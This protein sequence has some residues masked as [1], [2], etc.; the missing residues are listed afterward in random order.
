MMHRRFTVAMFIALGSVLLI[1]DVHADDLPQKDKPDRRRITPK[2]STGPAEAA[3]AEPATS[4]EKDT[5]GNRAARGSNNGN[6][7]ANAN[8][9]DGDED[10]RAERAS[11]DDDDDRSGIRIRV[12][13]HNCACYSCRRR[14]SDRVVDD[15][16]DEIDRLERHA[17]EARDQM[18]RADDIILAL[19]HDLHEAQKDLADAE[20]DALPG[21]EE[22]AAARKDLASASLKVRAEDERIDAIINRIQKN[23]LTSDELEEARSQ[24]RE[25]EAARDATIAALIASM[26]Q[27]AVII[28][29]EAQITKAQQT[30]EQLQRAD[31]RDVQ[32]ITQIAMQLV[33]LKQ[34]LADT[35]EAYV[36]EHEEVIATRATVEMLKKRIAQLELELRAA[37]RA[38]LN[39]DENYNT[40]LAD[41]SAAREIEVAMDEVYKTIAAEHEPAERIVRLEQQNID[42]IRSRIAEYQA[43]REALRKEL[44][45]LEDRVAD[46]EDR[47][48]DVRRGRY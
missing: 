1:G 41:R 26:N 33:Q 34:A 6:H 8:N 27:D 24:L 35:R 39:A 22:V 13:G 20:M 42:R 5:G 31:N 37:F 45:N 40:A 21:R 25:A 2:E 3:P 4:R 38:A 28:A 23:F 10:D 36:D 46:K 17:A 19:E 7:A 11:D 48:V 32:K 9:D 14:Y 12:H 30:M 44:V 43:R 47:I 16:K 15:L 18:D 29:A